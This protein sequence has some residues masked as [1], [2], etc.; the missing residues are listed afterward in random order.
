MPTA[1][2][3]GLPSPDEGLVDHTPKRTSNVIAVAFVGKN[4]FVKHDG[5]VKTPV[6]TPGTAVSFPFGDAARRGS[7]FGSFAEAWLVGREAQA[8]VD[9]GI[10]VGTELS[11]VR[12]PCP[13]NEM[14]RQVGLIAALLEDQIKV[15]QTGADLKTVFFLKADIADAMPVPPFWLVYALRRFG[16]PGQVFLRSVNDPEAALQRFDFE[17]TG[18][19]VLTRPV[20]GMVAGAFEPGPETPLGPL[21]PDG[22]TLPK[23]STPT[24]VQLTLGAAPPEAIAPVLTM[25]PVKRS[26]LF[27]DSPSDLSG[28]LTIWGGT[29][30]PHSRNFRVHVGRNDPG[31]DMMV[32]GWVSDNDAPAGDGTACLVTVEIDAWGRLFVRLSD[33]QGHPLPIHPMDDKQGNTTQRLPLRSLLFPRTEDE[34]ALLRP[35]FERHAET[36]LQIDDADS[37]TLLD[38]TSINGQPVAGSAFESREE[39]LRKPFQSLEFWKGQRMYYSEE[40]RLSSDQ[41][42]WMAIA[43]QALAARIDLDDEVNAPFESTVNSRKPDWDHICSQARGGHAVLFESDLDRAR[44]AGAAPSDNEDRSHRQ[45]LFDELRHFTPKGYA[46]FRE[47]LKRYADTGRENGS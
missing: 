35:I 23:E 27:F 30:T 42:S 44:R 32:F 38:N 15:L 31:G 36:G 34:T 17:P 11:E 4:A 21:D 12:T 8:L 25:L 41:L 7:Q 13:Q 6:A 26:K 33:P 47:E 46:R 14:R 9:S 28:R 37:V 45:Q 29:A 19:R 40:G 39:D 10:M 5:I 18:S 43:R 24:Q 22:S 20:L 3:Q 1:N 2:D 16:W